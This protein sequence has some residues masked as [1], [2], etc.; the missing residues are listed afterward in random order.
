M[1]AIALLLLICAAAAAQTA[2]PAISA[3]NPPAIQRGAT[4]TIDVEG[5]NLRGASAVLFDAPG[6]QAKIVHVTELPPERTVVVDPTEP[7]PIPAPPRHQVRLE[8]RADG[9]TE[10]GTHRFRL[11]TPLGTSTVASLYITPYVGE[12][13]EAEPNDDPTEPHKIEFLPGTIVGGLSRPG[14]LDYYEFSGRAGRQIVFESISVA[15]GSQIAPVFTVFNHKGDIV[16]EARREPGSR[17]TV[18]GFTVPADGKYLLRVGDFEQ[19]G[20]RAF[21]YRV[22]TGEFAYVTSLFPLGVGPGSNEVEVSGWNLGAARKVKVDT[23]QRKYWGETLKWRFKSPRGAALNQIE[24]P[25]GGYQETLEQEPNS[26]MDAAQRLSPGVTVNGRLMA[27]SGQTSTGDEDFFRFAARKGQKLVFEVEAQRFGSSLDSVLEIL[28]AKGNPVPRGTLRAVSETSIT[29]NDP[30]SVRQGM[31]LLTWPDM[32][33]TDYVKVGNEVVQID[34]LPFGPDDDVV[35]KSF[36]GVRAPVL[37]T[38]ASAH[39]VNTPVYKVTVH[40]PGATFPPNGLPTFALYYQND[41]GGPMFGKDSRLTFEAPSDGDYILRLRDVRGLHGERF[42]YRL[43]FREASPDFVLVASAGSLNL[44]AAGRVPL[45]VSAYRLDG[46]DGDIEVTLEG[47]SAGIT[48]TKG[49][50]QSGQQSTVITVAAPPAAEGDRTI[51]PV[52]FRVVGRARPASGEL[53]RVADPD[54]RLRFVAVHSRPPD[55]MVAAEPSEVVIEPG[56]TATVSVTIRRGEGINYRIPILV[57]NLPEGVIVKDF[58]LNG[59][60][61]NETETARTFVLEASPK[62]PPIEQQVFAVGAV[63][64]NP[65]RSEH[66]SA[67]FLLKVRPGTLARN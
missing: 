14:D 19:R 58:G 21:T 44:P 27:A 20:G 4:V 67:P 9:N 51:A 57:Q 59:V 41:D 61:I 37:E 30:D 65:V 63:E 3:V 24:L 53:V 11:Q 56:K 64:T 47:L 34:R 16:A 33:A 42:A 49:V 13:A 48:A 2:P 35:F 26:A 62:A 40:P 28:D 5:S 52:P 22:L 29:L 36:R 38:T 54:E 45:T 7:V 46:F 25:I 66:A 23:P 39:A 12:I 18:L 60:L 8:V 43:T 1:R 15:T 55:L 10:V 6:F 50:I 31:R 32:E 17:D